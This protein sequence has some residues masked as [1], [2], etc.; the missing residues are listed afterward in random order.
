MTPSGRSRRVWVDSRLGALQ[1]LVGAEPALLG[2]VASSPD[3]CLIRAAISSP[4]RE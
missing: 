4:E 1:G 3:S 2:S